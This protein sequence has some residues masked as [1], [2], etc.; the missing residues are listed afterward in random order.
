M[1]AINII[2]H[3]S[4]VAGFLVVIIVVAAFIAS[5]FIY[6]RAINYKKVFTDLL[7]IFLGK[8][9]ITQAR[10]QF[11]VGVGLILVGLVLSYI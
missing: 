11:F 1:S 9:S 3:I 10:N 7:N 5:F 4:V 6:M 8:H 2:G